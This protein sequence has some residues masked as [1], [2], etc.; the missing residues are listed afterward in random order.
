[1]ESWPPLNSIQGQ[2]LRRKKIYFGIWNF[3][4]VCW[5]NQIVDKI[6]CNFI[7]CVYHKKM[8]RCTNKTLYSH[9]SVFFCVN[10]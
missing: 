9:F 5:N 7:L 1:V 10:V 8:Q 3:C 2:Y 4:F 6:P